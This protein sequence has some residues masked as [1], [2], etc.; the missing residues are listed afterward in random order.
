MGGFLLLQAAF[1]HT[2]ENNVK[3]SLHLD[4]LWH[5]IAGAPGLQVVLFQ[6]SNN[7]PKSSLAPKQRRTILDG[8]DSGQIGFQEVSMVAF[9]KKLPKAPAATCNY[10]GTHCLG[11]SAWDP[12]T[13]T[14]ASVWNAFLYNFRIHPCTAVN[15][16]AQALRMGLVCHGVGKFYNLTLVY[17][18]LILLAAEW[19]LDGDELDPLKQ[20]DF[21]LHLN[22]QG[23]VH[24]GNRLTAVR[25]PQD[26][27][28]WGEKR[29][30]GNR[31]CFMS[32]PSTP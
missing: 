21:L 14:F 31:L 22:L 27:I 32:Y 19:E 12:Q 9:G 26:W 5:R 13:N 28:R 23:H 18:S 7:F 17:A 1:P 6:V 2:E 4:T 8:R 15:I 20:R 30:F 29:C 25:T 3:E 10:K 24:H 16:L 11:V